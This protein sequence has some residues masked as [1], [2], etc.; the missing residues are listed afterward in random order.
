MNVMVQENYYPH[1]S[2]KALEYFQ[3]FMWE[4]LILCLVGVYV[5]HFHFDVQLFLT[6]QDSLFECLQ[7]G[8]VILFVIL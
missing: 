7:P 3:E 6:E 1:P 8:V 2:D 5:K 4:K